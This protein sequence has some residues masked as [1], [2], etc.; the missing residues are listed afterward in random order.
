MPRDRAVPTTAELDRDK[1]GATSLARKI[2]LGKAECVPIR[3][4]LLPTLVG[5]D[6]TK[7][8][9]AFIAKAFE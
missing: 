9:N 8:L 1:Q 2:F 4:F 6:A 3:L 5:D 7:E